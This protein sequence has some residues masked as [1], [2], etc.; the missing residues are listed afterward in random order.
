MDNHLS[1]EGLAMEMDQNREEQSKTNRR[2]SFMII[3]RHP[4]LASSADWHDV[5]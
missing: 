5:M 2:T 1:S 3:A 4:T